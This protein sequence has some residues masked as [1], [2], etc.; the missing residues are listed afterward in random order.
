MFAARGTALA[1]L[2]S[3]VAFPVPA[4]A[5]DAAASAVVAPLAGYSAEASA[6]ERDWET[7]FRALLDTLLDLTV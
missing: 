2:P 4:A 5:Q 1:L 6:A 7:K 3:L